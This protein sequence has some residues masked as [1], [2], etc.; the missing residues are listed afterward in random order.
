MKKIIDLVSA[1]KTGKDE[2]LL[3]YVRKHYM[4]NNLITNLCFISGQEDKTGNHI[5]LS[6]DELRSIVS[7]NDNSNTIYFLRS[8]YFD[9]DREAY[10]K[11]MENMCENNIQIF[12]TDQKIEHVTNDK[13]WTD[14]YCVFISLEDIEKN[15]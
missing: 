5:Q 12:K 15:L 2:K 6:A 10:L 7:K 1:P 13:N 8:F 11:L 9:M 4:T 3:N 14:K